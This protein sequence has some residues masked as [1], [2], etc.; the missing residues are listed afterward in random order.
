[1]EV[2]I[3]FKIIGDGIVESKNVTHPFY[4]SVS[5]CE[6]VKLD[7]FEKTEVEVFVKKLDNDKERYYD[8]GS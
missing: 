1:M 2:F 8:G 7:C 3:L 5:K 6:V 4:F